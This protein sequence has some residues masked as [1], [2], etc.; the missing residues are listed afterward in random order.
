MTQMTQIF[1]TRQFASAGDEL[2]HPASQATE[3]RNGRRMVG[4][5][6]IPLFVFHLC[7]LCH[8]WMNS[9]IVYLLRDTL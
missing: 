9:W 6:D 1:G 5:F 8:L 2:E 7:H 4:R 3:S